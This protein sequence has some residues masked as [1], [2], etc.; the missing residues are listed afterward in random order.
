[1]DQISLLGVAGHFL[2]HDLFYPESYTHWWRIENTLPRLKKLGV[3]TVHEQLYLL[4]NP[5]RVL[6]SDG[7]TDPAVLQKMHANRQLVSDW[8]GQYDAAGIKV[9]LS[10]L[11]SPPSAPRAVDHHAEFSN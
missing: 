8:L 5:A 7:R 2:H 9:V 3:T 4:T 6:V 11:A 1:M 10:V